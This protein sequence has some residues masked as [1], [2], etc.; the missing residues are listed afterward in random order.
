[1]FDELLL[2]LRVVRARRESE[3]T[4]SR[5]PCAVVALL[6]IA[7]GCDP[8]LT[9]VGP[10]AVGSDTTGSDTSGSDTTG[11][12][13]QRT[14]I[15]VRVRLSAGD[16]AR[17]R[18]LGW[19]DRTVPDAVVSIRR[20]GSL[21]GTIDT[22]DATGQAIFPGLL[23]GSYEI[24]VVRL[25]SQAERESLGAA[26]HSVTSFAGGA[27]VLAVVPATSVAVD[28]YA[29]S[30]GGLLI[31][32]S[33]WQVVIYNGVPYLDGGFLELYNNSDTTVFLDGRIIGSAHEGRP[34]STNFPCS[35]YEPFMG[36]SAGLWARYLYR[37]P[38]SGTQYP[39]LP[40]ANAVLAT[41]AI[42][43]SQFF[44]EE[45]DLSGADFESVG[46]SD[47]D[48]PAVPNVIWLGPNDVPL[49]HGFKIFQ[50]HSVIF[51]AIPLDYAA[52]EKRFHP[53]YDRDYVFVPRNAIVEVA[54]FITPYILND[55]RCKPPVHRSLDEGPALKASGN[56]PES[57]H[58][59]MVDRD[60]GNRPVLLKTN[61]SVRDFY[62]DTKSPFSVP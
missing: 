24:G 56:N 8:S 2:L 58:R 40:G 31:S 54:Q 12:T 52:L 27:T 49:G 20:A 10:R 55:E 50:S 41:D 33:S 3:R 35:L 7:L 25:L 34:V 60:A 43:H 6:L 59:R 46:G 4:G 61:S 36:D 14:T 5:I 39:L 42:D 48:N 45:V 62:L 11:G 18:L 30:R 32:E 37:F 21:N 29:A 17:A 47:V 44:P 28:T 38:G 19:A 1:M 23:P 16:T 13:V 15:G 57:N 22:T 53:G 51:L 26:D 9:R